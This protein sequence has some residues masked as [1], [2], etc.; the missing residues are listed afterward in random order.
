MPSDLAFTS[1]FSF[2][3]H[4]LYRLYEKRWRFLEAAYLGGVH[5]YGQG[6]TYQIGP[7]VIRRTSETTHKLQ[8]Q[9]FS[10][11]NHLWR[12]ERERDETYDR[13]LRAAVYDNIFRPFIDIKAATIAKACRKLVLPPAL[14]HMTKDCDRWGT[15][16]VMMRLARNT[17]AQVCGAVYTVCEKPPTATPMPSRL[18]ELAAGI[19]CYQRLLSPLDLWD[20]RWSPERMMFDWAL[21]REQRPYERLALDERTGVADTTTLDQRPV[22]TRLYKPGYSVLYENGKEVARDPAPPFVPISVQWAGRDP[23]QS[24]PIGLD[25]NGDVADLAELRFN[26]RSW[27][28]D[29]EM[30]SCFN[31]LVL[32]TKDEIDD[33]QNRALGTHTYLAV[34]GGAS[35]LAPQIAPMAHLMDSMERDGHSMRQIMGLEQRGEQSVAARSGVALQL[36]AQS[37]SSKLS[38]EAVLAEGGERAAWK[39]CA[40][41]EGMSPEQFDAEFELEYTADFSQLDAAAR[42]SQVMVALQQGGFTGA[43]K[44]ALQKSAILGALPDLDEEERETIMEDIDAGVSELV[45]APPAAMPPDEEGELLDDEHEEMPGGNGMQKPMPD[46]EAKM[47][48]AF[49]QAMRGGR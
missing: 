40:A 29:Q 38:G 20:W 28:S 42:F 34:E 39:M 12:H 31:Q 6:E 27:L 3:Y 22:W 1:Q 21:V 26:K 8:A 16:A 17:W 44:A 49:A 35:F 25:V 48:P 13:R 18:H 41:L 23:R 33:E 10:E 47:P 9:T 43:A 2:Q 30:A 45:V 36:E 24:E 46:G 37:M 15:S 11:Q 14:E 7:F 4:P 19:R 32:N 5:W